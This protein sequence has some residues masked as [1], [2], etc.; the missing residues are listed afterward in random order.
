MFLTH[1]YLPVV[2]MVNFYINVALYTLDAEHP[3]KHLIALFVYCM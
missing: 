3:N 2:N 1:I